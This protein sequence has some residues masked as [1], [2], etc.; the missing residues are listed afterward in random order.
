[1]RIIRT[2][3][4]DLEGT[5]IDL[6][7][8]HWNGHLSAAKE[9]G[10]ELTFED[11]IS[12]ISHFIGGPDEKIAEEI[13]LL[14]GNRDKAHDFLARDKRIFRDLMECVDTVVV[15]PGFQSV[16]HELLDAGLQ[17]TI[18]SL[19]DKQLAEIILQKSGLGRIIPQER[20][21]LREEVG[22]VKPAPD[23]YHRTAEIAGV[24]PEEQLVFED[25]INGVLAAQSAGSIVVA[26]PTWREPEFVSRL[27]RAGARR[28]FFEWDEIKTVDLI[29]NLQ[30]ECN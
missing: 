20:I 18:G 16:L 8:V 17:I 23:V 9:I 6:E 11:A 4:F 5:L 21:V 2:V 3:A 7:R 27:I 30:N 13:A 28:V 12:K 19:T 24:T 22:N 26:I 29:R 1:M 14:A 10:I 25:S 15:R